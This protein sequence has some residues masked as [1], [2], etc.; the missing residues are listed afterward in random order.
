[1]YKIVIVGAGP[2]GLFAAN[3]L[4]NH[5]YDVTVIDKSRVVGGQGLNI[6]GKFNFHPKIGGDLTQFL[7]EDESW[8]VI[9]KIE[10]T[11]EKYWTADEN[12]DEEKLEELQQKA[13]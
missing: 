1:M 11:F 13:I 9:D 3:E 10:K 7:P 6:D 4:I 8:R 2:A 12:Y 5:A